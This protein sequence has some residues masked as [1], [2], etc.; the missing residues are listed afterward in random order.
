MPHS[1]AAGAD[2]GNYAAAIMRPDWSCYALS[3][4]DLRN[5][6]F[7]KIL[8]IKLSAVGDV[9]HTIPVL[10]KLRRR[11]PTARLDWLVTPPIAELLR[12]HPGITNI[13]EFERDAWLTPWRL[14][15]F[16]AYA[17]LIAKLR[18]TAYDLVIDMHGQFRTAALALAT[19]A[20]ARIGFDR[21]RVGVWDA[22]PRKFPEQARK[23]AWQ[24]A[25]EGSWLAYTHHIAVPT[26]DL[27]AVDRYLNVSS[28]LGLD[29]DPANF[30]FPIPQ[31]A[32]SRIDSLLRQHGIDRANFV[33]IAPGTIWET[34]HWG[35]DKFAQIAR[36]FMSKGLA[37][38]LIGS[39]RERII[40]EEVSDLAPGAVDLAGMTTLSELAAL[41]QRSTISITNDSGPMHLA[42]ALD[43][44]VVSIFGPTDS[45][46]I[47]PYR[48]T[49]AVLHADLPCSPCYLRQLKHC[50]HGH[51]CMHSV[52]TLAVI[53]RAE[54]LL[55]AS[56][57]RLAN[58]R[59]T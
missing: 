23:H 6:D 35:N 51:A 41:I 5:Q 26:L 42:V 39:Q 21:P 52:S 4:A 34:K 10:N 1:D 43:R 29:K 22:S 40:C 19:G 28:I 45:I 18:A 50:N 54:S 16:A 32:K 12:H 30:S 2:R 14:A 55:Q 48:R 24:G 58:A 46:W 57:D 53:E 15:P 3:P 38:V 47:G 33:T 37:A 17:R 7:Q 13:I 9:V 56:E 11:Y 44:P 27:H 25:R 59:A 8:L 36:H 31:S 20:P 49:N